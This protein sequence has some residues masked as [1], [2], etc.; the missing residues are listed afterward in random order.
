MNLALFLVRQYVIRPFDCCSCGLSVKI[1]FNSTTV[2]LVG[3]IKI[4]FLKSSCIE[5]VCNSPG[6]CMTRATNFA[7]QSI[8]VH[9]TKKDEGSH[10]PP[11]QIF[12]VNIFHFNQVCQY[13][14]LN[15]SETCQFFM[16][17]SHNMTD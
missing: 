13:A 7:L 9:G 12:L 15:K 10:C 14:Y 3:L 8:G 17:I 6:C 4:K 2:N 1:I 11:P 16:L 5:Y